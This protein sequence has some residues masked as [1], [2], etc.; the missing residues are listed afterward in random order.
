MTFSDCTLRR[1]KEHSSQS[2]H[3]QLSIMETGIPYKSKKSS[4][5][6]LQPSVL[7]L[8]SW[9]CS[10]ESA[11]LSLQSSVCSF[12][13]SVFSLQ[14]SVF[15]LQSTVCS[16]HSAVFSLQTSVFSLQSIPFHTPFH[17]RVLMWPCFQAWVSLVWV[18]CQSLYKSLYLMLLSESH[19]WH[20]MAT[21]HGI[22]DK[23]GGEDCYIAS[24]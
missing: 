14:S 7:S 12:Q 16:L 3:G 10:L 4:V 1:S 13:S 5:F 11:V 15:S 22:P 21:W 9:V 19:Q 6:S 20:E 23:T 24:Y 8:Q 17:V 18:L 2:V